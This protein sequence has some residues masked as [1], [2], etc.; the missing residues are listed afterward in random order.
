MSFGFAEY[1]PQEEYQQI[2]LPT[3]PTHELV[4]MVDEIFDTSSDAA[5]VSY[6]YVVKE[7]SVQTDI[8]WENITDLFKQ[9]SKPNV[10]PRT[11]AEVTESYVQPN[12]TFV[13]Q[14]ETGG[15]TVPANVVKESEKIIDQHSL[16]AMRQVEGQV[17][18]HSRLKK[19][20]ICS[21]LACKSN[22][23]FSSVNIDQ[24]IQRTSHDSS[25]SPVFNSRPIPSV[26]V[27]LFPSERYKLMKQ[28]QRDH[29]ENDPRISRTLRKIYAT[30]RK[31]EFQRET[32]SSSSSD[33]Y[34]PLKV[35]LCH[36]STSDDEP[37]GPDLF[38]F[39][40]EILLFGLQSHDDI[41]YSSDL[42]KTQSSQDTSASI[43]KY[44]ASGVRKNLFCTNSEESSCNSV[45][46][47]RVSE[48]E[49]CLLKDIENSGSDPSS[50]L[51]SLF[52]TSSLER[53]INE[54]Q[55]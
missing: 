25:S 16:Q 13:K 43:G 40:D 44:Y 42:L 50:A 35:P 1:L 47:Q 4:Q 33:H 15:G 36:I 32:T 20:K 18:R 24:S 30:A 6:K 55:L 23:C 14:P 17:C 3:F 48:L 29:F 26:K 22:I 2:K 19:I 38:T 9:Q 39:N 12:A 28:A 31:N 49:Q 5:N 27:N 10:Q 45:H 8:V 46:G 41:Q 52:S 54:I 21:C 34:R 11:D 37:L 53:K 51:N 7:T